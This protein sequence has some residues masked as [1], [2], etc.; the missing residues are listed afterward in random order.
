MLEG[1]LDKFPYISGQVRKSRKSSSAMASSVSSEIVELSGWATG[2]AGGT[3][4][5]Q[6]LAAEATAEDGA[7]G[8]AK[9]GG[10][11][12]AT[13]QDGGDAGAKGSVFCIYG[14]RSVADRRGLN[15][16]CPAKGEAGGDRSAGRVRALLGGSLRSV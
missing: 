14:R 4:T 7:G 8:G 6:L 13:Q 10:G 9:A 5:I 2:P 11:V 1:Y 15:W 3:Q 12:N 16:Q